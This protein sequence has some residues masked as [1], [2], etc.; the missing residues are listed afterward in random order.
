MFLIDVSIV[1]R[2]VVGNSTLKVLQFCSLRYTLIP[3]KF[4]KNATGPDIF[5]DMQTKFSP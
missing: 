2:L 1:S 5:F 3:L 4:Q